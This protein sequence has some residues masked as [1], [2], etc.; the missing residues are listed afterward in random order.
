[1][2][3]CGTI[4]AKYLNIENFENVLYMKSL[5]MPK[6]AIT[7]T[8]RVTFKKW[9]RVTFGRSVAVNTCTMKQCLVL[10]INNH[11]PLKQDDNKRHQQQDLTWLTCF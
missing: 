3:K 5:S 8:P 6:I 9:K 7:K 10:N 2:R 1:M 4:D 11:P